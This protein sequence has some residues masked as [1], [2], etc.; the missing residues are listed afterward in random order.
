MMRVIKFFQ[1]VNYYLQDLFRSN[2]IVARDIITPGEMGKPAIIKLE[3]NCTKDLQI[4]VLTC[5]I[6]MSPGSLC[7]KISKDRKH[8]WLHYLYPKQID[9]LINTIKNKYEKL[10]VEIF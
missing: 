2:M 6:S 5:L 7:L 10:I 4:F 3:I 8:I 9:A 1:L